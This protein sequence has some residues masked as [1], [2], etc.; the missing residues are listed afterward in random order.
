MLTLYY[1]TFNKKEFH[2]ECLPSLP[3][4]VLPIAVASQTVVFRIAN[5]FGVADRFVFSERNDLLQ[6]TCSDIET[7]SSS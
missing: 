6:N 3:E 2:P 5:V 1:P 4:S 7:S